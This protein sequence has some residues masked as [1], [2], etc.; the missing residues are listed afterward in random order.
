M[1]M[2]DEFRIHLLV[3]LILSHG[4]TE[5]MC[6][7]DREVGKKL[8]VSPF[9]VLFDIGFNSCFKECEAYAICLSIN[10]NRIHFMCEMNREKRNESLN[11]VDDDSFIYKEIPGILEYQ[12]KKCGDGPCNE[13]SKCVHTEV[14]GYIC[15]TI[16]C[17]D[18]IPDLQNGKIAKKTFY[19]PSVTF[20]CNPGYSGSDASDTIT[21]SPWG[22]W[23]TLLYECGVQVNGGWGA[24]QAWTPCYQVSCWFGTKLRTRPCNNPLPM[25]GGQYCSG[26]PTEIINCL[27]GQCPVFSTPNKVHNN[28]CVELQ[29]NL[30]VI[31]N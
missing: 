16:G 3:S 8:P 25:Y 12:D 31:F 15:I 14:N 9:T 17:N 7:D 11:L 26:N 21:C 24:W 23:S 10:F 30:R 1:Y 18:V 29:C 5:D 6:T 13:Y 19:P 27:R 2:I 22:K 4:M 20:E 28:Q